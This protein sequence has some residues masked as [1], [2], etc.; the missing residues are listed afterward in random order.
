M[1]KN[2]RDKIKG[3]TLVEVLIVMTV[4]SVTMA[5]AI[6]AFSDFSDKASDYSFTSQCNNIKATASVMAKNDYML[7]GENSER[8]CSELNDKLAENNSEQKD[9]RYI[10]ENI[11][12]KEGRI[13]QMKI[14]RGKDN[15][16]VYYTDELQFVDKRPDGFKTDNNAYEPEVTTTAA[17]AA[18]TV[19]TV[20]TTVTTTEVTTTTVPETSAVTTTAATTVPVTE[21]PVT[22]PEDNGIM[23]LSLDDIPDDLPLLREAPDR[24]EAVKINSSYVGKFDY[25]VWY[26]LGDLG[27]DW[28]T[29]AGVSIQFSQL[30]SNPVGGVFVGYGTGTQMTNF[31]NNSCDAMFNQYDFQGAPDKIMFA[32]YYGLGEITDVIFYF[33]TEPPPY[34]NINGLKVLADSSGEYKNTAPEKEAKSVTIVFNDYTYGRTGQ[35]A[36]KNTDGY[37]VNVDFNMKRSDEK[38]ITVPVS[39]LGSSFRINIYYGLSDNSV[40]EVFIN[41]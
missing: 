1:K 37:Y 33:I 9:E 20:T 39:K 35:I 30:S 27:Y 32:N 24:V 34:T 41:Y 11:L 23:L 19:T 7:R 14:T 12:V 29:F 17:T 28:R 3:F 31:R 40:K 18:T 2:F 10:V 22:E 16:M 13:L 25:N 5:I 6:P 15:R 4:M 21:E 38:Y 26:P 36:Y 8:L